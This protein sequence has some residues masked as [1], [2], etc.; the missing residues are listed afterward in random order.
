ML[1]PRLDY[2][3][4]A[5]AQ[6]NLFTLNFQLSLPIENDKNLSHIRMCMR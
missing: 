6:A 4:I 2:E 5:R 1:L 3:T